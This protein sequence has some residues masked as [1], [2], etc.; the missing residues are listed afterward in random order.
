[1]GDVMGIDFD[2]TLGKER[3]LTARRQAV[4]QRRQQ[5]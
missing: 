5:E 3:G 4:A 2:Y 1:M